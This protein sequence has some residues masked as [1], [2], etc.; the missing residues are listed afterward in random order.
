MKN[1][2]INDSLKKEQPDD[3][4]SIGFQID[5]IHKYGYLQYNNSEKWT[6]NQIQQSPIHRLKIVKYIITLNF[7]ILFIYNYL[8]RRK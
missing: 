6:D 4:M 5:R 7:I 8:E 2:Y 1:K 3:I